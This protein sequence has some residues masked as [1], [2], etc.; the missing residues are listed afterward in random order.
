MNTADFKRIYAES[1]NGVDQFYIHPFARS[2]AYSDGVKDL[3]DTGC[4]WLLDILATELP[5]QFEKHKDISNRCCLLVHVAGGKAR[6]TGE[7]EDEV[8]GWTSRISYTDLPNGDWQLFCADE[9]AG[10][11]R[12]KLILLTE[13]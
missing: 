9:Y 8:V 13:Y 4:H 5:E 10:P 2:F 7:W 1:R 6:I 3:A 11:S 12:Y